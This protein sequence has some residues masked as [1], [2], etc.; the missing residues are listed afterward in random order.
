MP[1]WKSEIGRMPQIFLLE[2]KRALKLSLLLEELNKLTKKS[3]PMRKK[4]KS[5]KKF[6]ALYDKKE[7]PI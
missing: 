7:K 3:W 4:K 2:L 1:L 6:I 5:L